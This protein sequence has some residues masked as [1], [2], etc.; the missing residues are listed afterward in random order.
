MRMELEGEMTS[1]NPIKG[2]ETARQTILLRIQSSLYIICVIG[3]S[4]SNISQPKFW[5]D[6]FHPDQAATFVPMH[7]PSKMCYLA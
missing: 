5:R 6:P 1:S 4:G 3:H 2:H 7:Y